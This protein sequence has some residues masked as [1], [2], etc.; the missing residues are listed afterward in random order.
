MEKGETATIM[1]MHLYRVHGSCNHV[2]NNILHVASF[3]FS[4]TFVRDHL[5]SAASSAR[6]YPLL[7]LSWEESYQKLT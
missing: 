2:K 3:A 6:L 5:A 4:T 7:V 1:F